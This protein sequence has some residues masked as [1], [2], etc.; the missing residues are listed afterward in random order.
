MYRPAP[1]GG[2]AIDR[3]SLGNLSAKSG[4]LFSFESFLDRINF[5]S[6][7]MVIYNLPKV[8][9]ILSELRGLEF[10]ERHFS[11]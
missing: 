7:R 11:K 6:H 5:N 4:R 8:R 1:G 3:K 10:F 2:E 9:N